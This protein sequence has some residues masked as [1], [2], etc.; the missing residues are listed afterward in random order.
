M[1]QKIRVFKKRI[2]ISQKKWNSVQNESLRIINSILTIISRLTL[3]QKN[4]TFSENLL[5]KF[6]E[7]P[8]RIAFYLTDIINHN[9]SELNSYIQQFTE[10]LN[11]MKKIE[12]EFK[13][14]FFVLIKKQVI[15]HRNP[16]SLDLEIIEQAEETIQEIV[17][18]Y[19]VEL[20]L[21][22]QIFH[23]LQNP[24]DFKPARITANLVLWSAEVYIESSRIRDLFE[25]FSLV[26]KL[27]EKIQTENSLN[28][29]SK[30]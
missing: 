19:Q 1:S 25:G 8:D 5:E 15:D 12:K 21:R 3:T 26:E 16:S 28:S 24:S 9:I 13:Q 11:E 30:S 7:V 20:A 29:L 4:G 23:E 6:P 27:C 2:Q 10:I 14:D 22:N 17:D 18:M